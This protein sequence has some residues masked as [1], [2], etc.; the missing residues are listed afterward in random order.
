MNSIPISPNL[1]IIISEWF[2]HL[3]NNKKYSNHTIK[4]YITDL[5]YFLEFI[6]K[7]TEEKI[8]LE[9]LSK[10]QVR[11]FRSWL[12]ARNRENHEQTSNARALS[13]I[14]SFFKYLKKFHQ[15]DNQQIAA[16]KL[17][18]VKKPLP[19][20]LS[21]EK[22]IEASRAIS[23]LSDTWVGQRDL[24]LLTLIYGTGLRIGE[25]LSL[26]KK[27]IPVNDNTPIR[28]KGKGNKERIVPVMN[29][30]ISEIEK[31][32]AACP[33]NLEEGPLFLGERGGALNPDVFRARLRALRGYLGL[34]EH[35]TPHSFRHSFATHLL[36]GGGDIR[37]IQELLGH[38]N[39]STTQRYTKIDAENLLV[40]YKAFHPLGRK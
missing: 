40:N 23:E 15:V 20:A 16:I 10:L 36:A 18:A 32:I 31:Y 3:K 19:K 25:A 5:F 27:D 9:E 29:Y 21:K 35:T 24:A 11:D 1:K 14:R 12:A 39:I 34:P 7:H 28:V 37:T 6:H 17:G 13:V 22:A 26:Q 30:V 4:A 33:Y 8:S 2:N 38:E